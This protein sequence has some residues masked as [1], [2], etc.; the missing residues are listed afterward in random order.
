[1][2]V[3]G[4]IADDGTISGTWSD[5]YAG[6]SREGTLNTVSGNATAIPTTPSATVTVTIDK[7]IDGEKATAVSGNNSDFQ[8]NAV[9]DAEN[10]GAGSGQ[11]TLNEDNSYKAET[12]EMTSGADYSTNEVM[13]SVV[14]A[15]C[16]SDA[17]FAL[18]GYTTGNTI[19]EAALATPSLVA[20]SFVNIT[21]DK[22]V[23]VWNTDCSND[24]QN[25]EIGGEVIG[26]ATNGVLTVTSIEMVDGT[27]MADGSF[28]NGWEY[29]F[30]ITVP[31]NENDVSMKFA[32]WVISGGG[33]TIAAGNNIR[34]SSPQANNAGA[35]VLIT[36][37]NLYSS[38]VLSMVTDLNPAIDGIQ[39]KVTV[40]VKIPVGSVNGAYTTNYGVKTQ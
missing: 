4:T 40:E 28:E 20:P 37:A 17:P 35:T 22:F 26:G 29:V 16:P 38:P 1:M 12:V 14:S 9:W 3:L 24:D 15:S 8:M 21:N 36:A 18:V 23:I 25:G 39:V 27:A 2:H 6:G 7:Y 13:D 34:I 30:N 11:Y 33:S 19:E 31:T 32:D 5:N 10:I